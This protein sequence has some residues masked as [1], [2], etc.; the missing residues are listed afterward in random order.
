MVLFVR[1]IQVDGGF[2]LRV[3]VGRRTD[4]IT[5][6]DREDDPIHHIDRLYLCNNLLL[7]N[8]NS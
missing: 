8:T 3:Q 2:W 6:D 7:V 4:C 1:R 5:T